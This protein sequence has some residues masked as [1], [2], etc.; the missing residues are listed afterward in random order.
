MSEGVHRYQYAEKDHLRMVFFIF[1]AKPVTIADMSEKLSTDSYKG[2]RDFYP[3][4]QYIQDYITAVMRDV[5]ERFGYVEYNASVLEPTELYAAKTGEEI[6]EEQTYTFVDRGDRSVTLRPEMTPTVARMIAARKRELPFPL[7]WYS[8]PNLFRYERPQKGRL[9]EHWQLNVDLFGIEG[10]FAELEVLTIAHAIMTS[11]G[12]TDEQFVIKIND[13]RLVNQYLRDAGLDENQ[14]HRMQKLIDRKDKMDA[15]AF[16]AESQ[17]IAGDDFVYDPQPSDD[18]TMVLD[19]FNN[20]GITNI[21]FDP[22][23]MRGF[24]YYTG[25]VFEIYDT[26]AENNRA[27]F[28]GGRYDDLLAIFGEEKAP[29][30]GFGMGDVTI[31]DVLETYNLLPDYVSPTDLYLVVAAPEHMIQIATLANELREQGLAVA[32]GNP[33]K[34]V[35]DQIKHADKLAIPTVIVV[36][37]QE[38]A[39][40]TFTIKVLETGEESTVVREAIASFFTPNP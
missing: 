1:T 11:F 29:A 16:R 30:V 35:G 13:R 8:I 25:I 5:V 10:I 21:E 33:D 38:L 24:D 28:G 19:V 39:N 9:R 6:V 26:S 15:D 4:D 20:A 17:A 7:R 27:L 12:L 14:I 22:A 31:R 23:I 2:V 37:D 32:L 3:E 34:K 36:G 18:V 40:N